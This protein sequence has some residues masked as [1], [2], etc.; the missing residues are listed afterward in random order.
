MVADEHAV[1]N[2]TPLADVG[3]SSTAWTYL[4]QAAKPLIALLAA[5]TG[6]ALLVQLLFRY[7]TLNQASSKIS[8]LCL[9]SLSAYL[10]SSIVKPS[11]AF[12]HV[13]SVG[14]WLWCKQHYAVVVQSKCD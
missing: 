8:S 11:L 3:G 10:Q 5:T 1:S 13:H 6:I 4:P 9:C 14:T 2:A 7:I 12:V